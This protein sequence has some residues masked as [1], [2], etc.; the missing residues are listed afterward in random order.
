VNCPQHGKHVV[1]LPWAEGGARYTAMFEALAIE[2][3][4]AANVKRAAMLLR[5]TWDEAWALMERAVRRG[6]A[7]KAE[8]MPAQLGVDEKAVAKG[9][10]YMTLV[11]D[12]QQ[13]TVE[14]VGDGRSEASLAAYYEAFSATQRAEVEA[15]SMD[16]WPAYISA[17]QAALPQ[18]AEAIVFDR[19][20]LMQHVLRAVDRVRR[21]EHKALRGEG[22]QRLSGSKYLWLR[23]GADLGESAQARLLPLLDTDLKTARAWWMKE[24]LRTW[25]SYRSRGWAE[26][27]WR[28]WYFWATHSRL[29]PMIE[30]ARTIQ[31]HLPNVLTYF[32]RRVTNATAE[33]LNAKIATVQKRAC[34]FRN[35]DHFKIAVYFHC[36]G[37]DLLPHRAT[38]TKAG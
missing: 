30:A 8:R 4:L 25:W 29:A 6:R 10:A 22:D 13:A 20:H 14:Y 32:A 7:A 3:L 18:A 38:P 23:T 9:H 17:T 37:L 15:V 31:R 24:S 34:G 28:R 1:V 12:L 21:R 26:R 36:G 33:S 27:F 35:R 5:L 11:S 2:V 16:M 19:F